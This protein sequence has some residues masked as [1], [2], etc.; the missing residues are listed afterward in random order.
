MKMDLS[1]L[2]Y[3]QLT[4]RETFRCGRPISELVSDLLDQKVKLSAP[5]LRLTVFETTDPRTNRR[6]MKCIDN[7]R[8]FA[9]KE[10]A[11]AIDRKHLKVNVSYFSQETLH[12]CLRFI[13]NS[14]NTDGRD[15]ILRKDRRL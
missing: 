5:F 9:L 7:R 3:S 14:D 15:V 12:Q 2:R 1:V 10:Y 11:D 4:C 8:L 6:V 13:H